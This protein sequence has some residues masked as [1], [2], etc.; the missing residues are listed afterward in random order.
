MPPRAPGRVP[1]EAAQPKTGAVVQRTVKE[2][3]KSVLCEP[4]PPGTANKSAPEGTAERADR[5]VELVFSRDQVV[6]GIIIAEVLG[7]PRCLRR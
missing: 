2:P 3:E 1:P 4:A 5:G 7:R 6:Q